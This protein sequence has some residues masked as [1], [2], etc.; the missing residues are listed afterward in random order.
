LGV[1]EKLPVLS[2]VDEG[3]LSPGTGKDRKEPNDDEGVGV[4]PL[5]DEREEAEKDFVSGAGEASGRLK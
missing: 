5:P 4:E 1:N 3:A 2:G